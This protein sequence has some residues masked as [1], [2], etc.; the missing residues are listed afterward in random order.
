MWGI[1]LNRQS[2]LPLKRQ[3][4]QELKNRMLSGQLSS[5]EM[6]LSTREMSKAL[7]ISRNTV[8]EAYE[9]LISEGFLISR[10]GAAVCE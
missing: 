6:M 7:S 3:L 2:G 8:S 10:Q 1:E 9:M 5:G 4:Y